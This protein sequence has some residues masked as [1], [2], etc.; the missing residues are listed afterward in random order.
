MKHLSKRE[1][2]ALV[3]VLAAAG[4]Q[5]QTQSPPTWSSRP[6]AVEVNWT[7]LKLPTGERISLLGASY[8]VAVDDAWGVGPA[9]YGA[10]QGNYG[11]LFTAGFN[12]QWHLPIG[13]QSHLSAGLYAGAGGG[14]SSASVDFG[15][16]LM[17]RPEL[18]LRTE[19]G[20]WYIG[21]GVAHV[22]FPSGNVSDTGWTVMVG[23]T[24]RFLSF[25][26]GDAGRVG[27]APQRSG[28]GFDEIA[29]SAALE[30]PRGG[31]RSGQPLSGERAKVGADLRQYLTPAA[32]WGIEAAGAAAGG[33]DGYMEILANAGQDWALG[34]P[35]LR[36]GVQLA[37][38]LGGGG[39]VDTGSGWLLRA[40][41]TLRWIT[42][43]GP[44]LRL[45]ASATY[46]PSGD[47]HA[48]QW[49]AMLAVPI[50]KTDFAHRY[51]EVA[52]ASDTVREQ[53]WSLS[54]PYWREMRFKDGTHDAAGGLGIGVSR[55]LDG[56]WYGTAQAGSAAFG[57]AGA[58][59][60]GLVGV[61]A[62]TDRLGAGWRFGA[63]A[64]LGAAGGGSVDVDGGAI[65]QME[66]WAQWEGHRPNDRLR[67]RMGI[68]RLQTLRG[69]RHATPMAAISVGWAYGTLGP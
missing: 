16:G 55:D 22:R 42:P 2:L 59:S 69:D 50:E 17:L 64:L 20:N 12:A 24:D 35:R 47:Y 21:A 27:S 45:D 48:V 25:S 60:Y 9:V 19:F 61:G 28:M 29:L 54:L 40:G 44:T 33:S 4:A 57:H 6:A 67:V 43:W 8:M 51:G 14:L 62:K 37:G 49:R 32:W 31:T 18:S 65:G 56:R 36:A 39:D 23:H 34:S 11:G 52:F 15:G 13:R 41:P 1:L 58:F 26:P 7:P 63:E 5:A 10:A 46:A 68:G 66:A 38:G 30:E 53:V 3:S